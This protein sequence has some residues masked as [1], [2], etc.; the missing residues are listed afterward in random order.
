MNQQTNSTTETTT[1]NISGV[2][3][4]TNHEPPVEEVKENT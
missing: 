2:L 4:L 1:S 3:H